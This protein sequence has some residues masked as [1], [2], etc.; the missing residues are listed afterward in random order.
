MQQRG[1]WGTLIGGFLVGTTLFIFYYVSGA[2]FG[3]SGGFSQLSSFIIALFSKSYIASNG[4]TASSLGD[5]GV[6]HILYNRI[7]FIDIGIFIGGFVSALIGGRLRFSTDKGSSTSTSYRYAMA[8]F[9]GILIA[10][11]TRYARGCTSGQGLA[12]AGAFSVGGWLFLF[13]VFAGVYLTARLFR[14]QWL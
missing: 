8:F 11:S 6:T 7:F 3:A 4:Y 5:H 10:Y 9:G 1:Y 2:G 14:R 12:G 13:C